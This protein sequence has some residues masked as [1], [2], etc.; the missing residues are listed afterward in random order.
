M[1]MFYGAVHA[2]NAFE[3][4]SWIFNPNGKNHL[5]STGIGTF[6]WKLCRIPLHIFR[7]SQSSFSYFRWYGRY[8]LDNPLIKLRQH[9]SISSANQVPCKPFFDY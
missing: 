1:Y 8:S 5:G 2:F 9:L 4:C 7:L 6:D 3:G